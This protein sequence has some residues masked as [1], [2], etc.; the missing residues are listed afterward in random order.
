MKRAVIY[1]RFSSDRQNEKSCLD[2]ISLC[3][4]WAQ[5][6]DFNV[7][8][9]F[10][11]EA[12][13]GASIIGR[14]DLARLMLAAQNNQFDVVVCESLDRLSRDQA[15]LAQIRKQLA[16]NDI[17][18]HT[19]Q[20]GEVG[21]I[22]IGIKGLMGELFLADLAQ[23]TRRG[24]QAVVNDGRHAGGKA[25]GYDTVKDQKGVL[26]IN[27]EQALVVQRIF[28]Q[29]LLGL[30]PRQIAADLNA[31]NILSPRGGKWNASTINGSRSRQNGILQNRL[32]IGL[33]VWNRQRFIKDP[34]TGTRVSRLN[35]E[36]EWKYHDASTL[37]I[38]DQDVFDNVTKLKAS[39]STGSAH[40]HKKPKHVFSGLLKCGHCGASY[41]VL[42][43]DRL[44]CAGK[45]ERGDCS[46]GRTIARQHIEERVLSALA[47]K[48]AHP[49]YIS[50]YIKAYHEE[51]KVLLKGSRLEIKS[52]QTRLQS[53]TQ[54]IDRGVNLLL[55]GLAPDSL[56]N[57]INE[58]EIEKNS[59]TA[60]IEQFN[61]SHEAIELHPGTAD[62]YRKTVENLH[63]YLGK[64]T[65]Q[66]S[67][68]KLFEKVRD[69]VEKVVIIAPDD[70]NKEVELEVHG[71]LAALLRITDTSCRVSVVAG[72]GFEPTTFGL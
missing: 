37:R 24:L 58:L 63:E 43:R 66:A 62:K 17:S 44:G 39:K 33:I 5:A 11:D 47:S 1:S 52:K 30:T 13:S 27:A 36:T 50:A 23:K 28:D 14:L 72:A 18:I 69:L 71:Q 8:E 2:Q 32:Y 34:N 38:I 64:A 46:N 25:F 57:R 70:A 15:D 56:V 40:R 41:T 42:G 48:L 20:D 55:K 68:D 19:V 26:V 6:Q 61:Q 59:L 31:D 22:H 49:D 12:V 60:D 3:T 35:P 65:D 29:Y 4:E 10:R 16:F 51:R 53:L 67:K 54:E 21:T 9:V 45:R 7:I